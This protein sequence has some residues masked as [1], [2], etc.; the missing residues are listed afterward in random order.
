MGS[1]AAIRMQHTSV[2]I[3][4]IAAVFSLFFC[5]ISRERKLIKL[6]L[7]NDFI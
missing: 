5:V 3:R 1:A 4:A 2:I 7:I 6:M